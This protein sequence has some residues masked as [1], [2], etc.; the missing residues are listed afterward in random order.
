MDTSLLSPILTAIVGYITIRSNKKSNRRNNL[1]SQNL[2][3][4]ELNANIISNARIEWL[5]QV[6]KHTAD[7]IENTNLLC[8]TLIMGYDNNKRAVAL[9]NYRKSYYM[10]RLYF[11]ERD[12]RN[13]TNRNHEKIINALNDIEYE[14]AAQSENV[15]EKGE[16]FEEEQ[17]EEFIEVFC[18]ICAMYFK[19]VW[20][21]AKDIENAR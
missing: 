16:K 14:M 4:K 19:K 8:Y 9:S 11:S 7:H 20:E 2:K 1:V 17:L 5:E 18:D 12:L 13:K 3:E 21:E 15:I 6:R 10:M